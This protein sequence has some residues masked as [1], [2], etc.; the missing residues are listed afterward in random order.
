MIPVRNR[1]EVIGS[2][3]RREWSCSISQAGACACWMASVFVSNCPVLSAYLPRAIAVRHVVSG[4]QGPGD[5]EITHPTQTGKPVGQILKRWSYLRHFRRLARAF[6]RRNPRLAR[7]AGDRCQGGSQM[8]T[9]PRT[10]QLNRAVTRCA[11]TA[12]AADTSRP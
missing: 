10:P 6:E 9:P 2:P 1:G 4:R 8:R 7:G 5:E 12:H 11:I 3:R